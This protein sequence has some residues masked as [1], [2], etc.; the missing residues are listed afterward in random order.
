MKISDENRVFIKRLLF[1][2][3]PVIFQEVINALVNIL[4]TVMIGRAMGIHEVTAVSLA[5][6]VFFLYVLI[7]WGVVGGC[8]VFIGQYYGKGE[9]A[10]I[11]KTVGLGLT[12]SLIISVMFFIPSFFV[13]EILIGIFSQDPIVIDLGGRFL[14]VV[15]LSFFFVPI[16]FTRIGAMR[17]TGQTRI[18]M[19]TTCVALISN[20][21]FNYI[22]I[23]IFSAPLEVV[24]FGT[25]AAR[26]IELALQQYLI[27]RYR[28]VIDAK[29]KDYFSFDW[30]FVKG[31]FKVSIFIMLGLTTWSVGISTYNIAYG[32][33]G[34][35]AQGAVRIANSMLQLFQVFSNSLAMV[36]AIIMSNTLGSGNR[37][38]AIRY[39]RKCLFASVAIGTAMAIVLIVFAP[40]IIGFFGAEAN[41]E[42]YIQRIL[43]VGAV[44]MILKAANFTNT[45]GILRSGGDTK[46][47]F[48]LDVVAVWLVTIPLI[49]IGAIHFS[50]PIYFLVLLAHSEDVVKFFAATWRVF[51]NKWAKT[52]V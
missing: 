31:F 33:A 44:G 10:N 32:F 29:L 42:V 46:F 9:T 18:P 22:L 19:V 15:S 23:F 6:Q 2:A 45:I 4:D 5:T 35:N 47:T 50:L 48:I 26:F 49:F 3:P 34:T 17:S 11:H 28:L 37:E 13:P 12:C 20:F 1:L 27:K 41:V 30:A 14:R 25:V 36:S 8:N 39:S 21:I 38:L 24:A 40:F 51:S 7:F 52:L 43:W 16:T